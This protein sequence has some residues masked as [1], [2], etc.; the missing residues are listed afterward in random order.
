VKRALFLLLAL[1]ACDP[2]DIVVGGIPPKPDGG[3]PPPRRPCAQNG[4]CPP[5]AFCEKD[6]CAVLVG[7][8]RPRP[9]FCESAPAVVCG[10]NGVNY[11]NDCLRRAQGLPASTAGECSAAATCGGPSGATCPDPLASCARLLPA[12]ASCTANPEGTCW[13]VPPTCP[14]LAVGAWSPCAGG[15]CVETCAAIRSQA[16]HSRVSTCP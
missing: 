11:W 15:A 5:D 8:C 4:D 7:Q 9:I 14:S 6:D 10:C 1:A 3:R 16:P 12:A 2:V 13:V